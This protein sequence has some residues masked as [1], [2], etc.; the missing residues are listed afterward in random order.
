MK[1]RF[2]LTCGLLLLGL[3]TAVNLFSADQFPRK[4]ATRAAMRQ[5]LAFSDGIL[6]GMALEKYELI[7][8]NALR[9]RNMSQTNLWYI[10]KQPDYMQH[11][12]NFQKSIDALAMAA[13]DKNLDS[14][15]GAYVQM[16]KNC[17]ECHRLVR[18]EQQ[19]NV[20]K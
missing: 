11:M 2:L 18:R 19:H 3:F 15:T 6:E 1:T 12:T 16:T 17:V 20:P 9:M 14:V 5:K 10:T 8:K 7:S 4:L 13:A